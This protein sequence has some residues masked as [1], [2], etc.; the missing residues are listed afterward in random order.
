MSSQTNLKSDDWCGYNYSAAPFFWIMEGGQYE[1]TFAYGEVG[2]NAA[3]GTGGSYV[4]PDVIDVD[5]FLSGR[6][7]MLTKCQP[8]SPALDDLKEEKIKQQNET[9]IVNLLPTYT[10]EKKSAVDLS[11]IDYNR[12]IPQDIDPQDLRFVIED[13]WPTRGGM[14]TQNYTKL[15]WAKGS[16]NYKEGM[17]NTTLDPARACGEYCESVSGYPGEDWITRQKKSVVYREPSKPSTEPQYPF[18]GP[19]SQDTFSVGASSPEQ[20]PNFFYGDRFDQG[21]ISKVPVTMLKN[22]AI[23]PKEF[24]LIF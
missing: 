12:W 16:Y 3:G 14:D 20:G 15:A 13:M 5:S 21:S 9:N 19:Y 4:R 23:S 6:D 17:C 10:K 2:I 22:N 1:N 7:D 8:P 18:R 11:S 24:P